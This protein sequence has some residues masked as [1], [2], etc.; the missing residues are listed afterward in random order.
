[1]NTT[2]MIVG[3]ALFTMGCV[4]YARMRKR[5]EKDKKKLVTAYL[6]MVLGAMTAVWDIFIPS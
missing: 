4:F 3:G 2:D 6:V 5:K 1:M